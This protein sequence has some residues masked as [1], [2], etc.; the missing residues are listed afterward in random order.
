M[1]IRHFCYDIPPPVCMNQCAPSS[2]GC[3]CI[4]YGVRAGQS[5]PSVCG[6]EHAF[7][8]YAA[9]LLLQSVVGKCTWHAK[10]GVLPSISGALQSEQGLRIVV[11]QPLTP[12]PVQIMLCLRIGGC[13]ESHSPSTPLCRQCIAQKA[14][15][16]VSVNFK[17]RLLL[18]QVMMHCRVAYSNN[19]I[20]F[21]TC[22]FGVLALSLCRGGGG[23][24]QLLQ[25]AGEFYGG[26][27]LW[28]HFVF[29]KGG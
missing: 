25:G 15:A 23:G 27:V 6:V 12:H 5:L 10:N 16:L 21:F 28:E 13:C 1:G 11:S 26:I 8:P 14:S 19:A 4:S 17:P 29:K 22:V 2:N 3:C 20:V 9:S 7:P 18:F 24:G